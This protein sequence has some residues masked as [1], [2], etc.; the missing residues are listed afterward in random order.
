MLRTRTADGVSEAHYIRM[1][2]DQ[3]IGGI[4]FVGASYADAGPEH[5]RMLKERRIPIVLINAAEG[6]GWCRRTPASGSTAERRTPPNDVLTQD[7]AGPGG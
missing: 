5:G 4:I 6:R 2:L 1:L 7:T 3:N